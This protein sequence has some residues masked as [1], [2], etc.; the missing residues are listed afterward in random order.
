MSGKAAQSISSEQTSSR[1][2][3]LEDEQIFKAIFETA[4]DCVFVKDRQLRYVRANPAMEKLF[5]VSAGELA[6]K[7]DYELFGEAAKHIEE[8]DRRVL[9]GDT[10]KEEHNKIL[11][12]LERTFHVIK[13]PVMDDQGWITG[14]CGVA[15]DIT[16]HKDAL[17]A[18]ADSDG[19]YKDLVEKAGIAILKDDLEGRLTYANRAFAEMFGYSEEELRG[20]TIRSPLI[21][22]DDIDRILSYHRKRVS[23]KPA[24]T[25]YDF[26]GM[27][28]DKSIIHCE[29]EVVPLVEDGRLVGTRSYIWDIT[30][31]KRFE[32]SLRKLNRLKESLLREGTLESKLRSITEGVV[33]IVDADFCRIWTTKP[34]D[35][36][37][38]GCIHAT[39]RGGSHACRQRGRCLSLAASS[40]R[41]T[42]TDGKVHQRIPFGCYEIGK[43][44][45]GSDMKFI[46]NEVTREARIHN[47]QWAEE[48]GLVSF[49]GY[50]LLS[51][52][53]D[54]LGVLG[55]FSTHEITSDVDSML[56]DIANTTTQVIQAAVTES[57]LREN[58]ERLRKAQR[59][60]RVGDWSYNV[61]TGGISWSEEAFRLFERDPELGPPR[62]EEYLSYYYPDH[63][64]KVRKQIRRVIETGKS[65]EDDYRLRLPSGKTVWQHSTI[66][67]VQDQTGKTAKLAGTVHD[68]TKRKEAEEELREKQEEFRTLSEQSLVGIGIVRGDSV[69]Y[70]NRTLC[71][72]IEMNQEEMRRT[73]VAEL[74]QAVHRDDREHVVTQMRKKLAGDENA[75]IRY[76]YRIKRKDGQERWVD[77]YS[78]PI[79]YHGGRAILLTVVDITDQ[80]EAE[81]AL[82]A[83][84]KRIENLHHTARS[85]AGCRTEEEVYELTV[86]AAEKILAFRLCTL[87]VAKGDKLVVKAASSGFPEGACEWEIEHAGVA[88]ETFRSGKT[89]VFGTLEEI[90]DLNP[91]RDGFQ[92]GISSPIGDF[93]VFQ[94]DSEE[95]NAFYGGDVRLLEL[96]LGH[97]E[98]A[99]RRIRLQDELRYQAVR[100][101]LTGVY[102]R[103][104]FNEFIEQEVKR[105]TRY[106]HSIGFMLIDVDGFKR[107]NDEY[108]HQ[109]GD[110]VLRGV[111]RFL[112]SQIRSSEL[113]VRYG[114]D[115][116]LIFLPET[117]DGLDVVK[118]RILN[119]LRSWNENEKEF[120][121]DVN[122]SVGCACWTPGAAD[123]LNAALARADSM[124]YVHKQKNH[125]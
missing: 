91:T 62:F 8:I 78:K 25:R 90:A 64:E 65:L 113:L 125:R 70:A 96:L 54:C 84:R 40:G 99:V 61:K 51:S 71:G 35:L 76:S 44:A 16:E 74:I 60:G 104:Y 10:V 4:D 82:L 80:K 112:Q 56:E 45:T 41:Y 108:G 9:N 48:L 85:M 87:S 28:K 27:R 47:H 57:V 24:P 37:D 26:K 79:S 75:L 63:A 105:S 111:A 93:G 116:F 11:N 118:D 73:K 6:G 114:G 102:N 94:V 2:W 68:I 52:T 21:H 121:F 33:R 20:F 97:T 106:D 30:Q 38:S 46:T 72:I 1:V 110:R 69:V 39:V 15:R 13:T 107:I 18:L 29:V 3:T 103:R 89:I 19:R 23:G 100:D 34:G 36:C 119:A 7:T 88:G 101:P 53:G 109:T 124:M 83:S 43:V 81:K 115:E 22:P 98:E 58:G 50:K 5:G 12:G 123:S 14:L 92:S 32:L 67:P 120:D 31:R 95:E 59:M 122:L 55:L 49:A 66:N 86:D 117:C 42:H 17:R 77:Q